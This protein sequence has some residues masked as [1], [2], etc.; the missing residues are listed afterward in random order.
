LVKD[1]PPEMVERTYLSSHICATATEATELGAQLVGAPP[2]V[3]PNDQGVRASCLRKSR[4]GDAVCKS[5]Q[6]E[7]K[8]GDAVCK[9]G[10]GE[11]K[12]GDAVCKSGDTERLL[13]RSGRMV[14]RLERPG[15]VRY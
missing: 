7:S 12:S 6:G 15:P 8:S 3:R 10:Q 11:S 2:G 9:S 1:A 14:G 13:A 4:S 5:G